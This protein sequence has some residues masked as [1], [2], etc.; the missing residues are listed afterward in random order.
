MKVISSK[1]NFN[2]TFTTPVYHSQSGESV[3]TDESLVTDLLNVR[4]MQQQFDKKRL[5]CTN[6]DLLILHETK[7]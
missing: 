5:E 4:M 2:Q 7:S 6:D 3:V 1:A